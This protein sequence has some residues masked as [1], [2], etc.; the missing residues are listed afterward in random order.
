MVGDLYSDRN[1]ELYDLKSTK[2]LLGVHFLLVNYIY[3]IFLKQK[4]V[5]GG[6]S[7]FDAW[8]V[9]LVVSFLL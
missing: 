7:G 3:W 8:I 2:G 1:F 6:T 5:L 4:S 9:V